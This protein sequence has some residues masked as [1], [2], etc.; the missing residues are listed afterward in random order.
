LLLHIKLSN[1]IDNSIVDRK[2]ALLPIDT[3]AIDSS[4]DEA[5][6]EENQKEI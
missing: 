1:I 3:D 5:W 6:H 2:S 4:H